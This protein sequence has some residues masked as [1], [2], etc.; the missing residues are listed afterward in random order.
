MATKP[1]EI[2]KRLVW[3]SYQRVKA[4]RGAA[5]IDAVSID[6]FD[7]DRNRNLYRIWNRLSS[8]SYFPPAVKAVPIPKKSGGT[9][10]LGVPTVGDRIAQTA[11]V[12]VLEPLLEPV[13]HPDSYGYRPGKSAHDA[14]AVTRQRCWQRDWVL[15]YDIRGLFDNID[16]HLLLKALRHHCDEPWVLLHVQRWLTVPMKGQGGETI[17]RT[18]GTP[19]GGPLSPILANLFLHY[20][21]DRWLAQTHPYIP[22]CRYADD[23]ILHCNSEAQALWMHEQLA[24]R[25]GACGLEMHPEK[26]R[27]VYSKDS[28]R[29]RS[30][31]HIQ[32]DFLGYTFRPRRVASRHGRI[33]TGFTPAL[34][35]QAMKGMRQSL[36]QRRLFKHSE[37]SLE[38]LA[39]L[40]APLVRGWMAYYCRFRG[41][42]FQSIAD[43]IDG[44]IVR[45]AMRKFK[46]L[47]GHKMRALAWLR[48][49]KRKS[50][51]LFVHWCGRGD[52]A[53]G[54]TGAR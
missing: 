12:L 10:T 6:E 52:Y 17:P 35:R 2:P 27:V 38:R 43:H 24:T 49:L 33:F 47:R 39:E 20:A 50:P 28:R 22:F 15:E 31:E 29:T 3:E 48:R 54:T 16:H 44:S 41:S 30:Y 18:V 51:G 32:F 21:L 26:T 7:R 11:V 25:L 9:R 36:R 1:F 42:E 14:I 13:F 23:G 53:V 19:Q 8:G 37:L 5:G 4:N 34:S 45:W 40:L 46:R